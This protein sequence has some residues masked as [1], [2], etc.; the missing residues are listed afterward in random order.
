MPQKN[1]IDN[2]Q[3]DHDIIIHLILLKR[4]RLN[5]LQKWVMSSKYETQESNQ[6][7]KQ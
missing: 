5:S 7:S 4:F 3:T 1:E 2:Q 6:E